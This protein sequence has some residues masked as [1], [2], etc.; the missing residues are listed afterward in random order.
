MI[1]FKIPNKTKLLIIGIACIILN[2]VLFGFVALLSN[3]NTDVSKSPLSSYSVSNTDNNKIYF[4]LNSETGYIYKSKE[5]GSEA[6]KDFLSKDPKLGSEKKLFPRDFQKNSYIT[7]TSKSVGLNGSREH[8]F[9]T[10]TLNGIPIYATTLAVHIKNGGEIYALSGNLSTNYKQVKQL[11][12][13][14]QAIQI[15]L[16]EA[17]KESGISDLAARNP[18]KYYLNPYVADIS[19]DT[20]NHLVLSLL[21]NSTSDPLSYIYIYFVDLENGKIIYKQNQVRD[22]LTRKIKDCKGTASLGCSVVRQEGDGPSGIA[23]ADAAYSIFSDVYSFYLNKFNRDSFDGAGAPYIGNVNFNFGQKNASWVG[24]YQSMFFSP[25]LVVKDITWHELTHALT[26]HTAGLIYEKQS[27]ALNE[28]VSDMFATSSDNNWTIGEGSAVGIIRS[29]SNPPSIPPPYGP[30]PDKLFSNIYYCG[31]LT[32]VCDKDINDNCGVHINSGIINKTFYLMSDGGNFNGCAISGI[33]RERSTKI[34]YNVLINFLS[35][36][37]NFYDMYSSILQACGDLYGTGSSECV[38]VKKA[39]QATEL[40]QQPV[41]TQVGPRCS[42]IPEKA[43]T[44]TGVPTKVIP[45]ELPTST[46][47]ATPT[48]LPGQPTATPVPGA[49]TSTPTPTTTPAVTTPTAV[50]TPVIIFQMNGTPTPTP[51]Q[52]FTCIPDPNCAKSGKTIQLCPLIC[53]PE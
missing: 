7:R 4:N 34:I 41:G 22:V 19:S 6:I 5:K 21:V 53:T 14:E 1:L 17:R 52:Y 10:Q 24:E 27:G 20:N 42:K 29:F 44:C 3:K 37:S 45:T 16:D 36:S 11:L 13:N 43:A 48:L 33:G 51:D 8:Y 28:S 47:T 15:T 40:D 26:Q 12:T 23:D 25:G 9:L 49:P 30:Q 18:T 39:A 32:S 50:P 2:L 46:P 38:E 35:P 31:G